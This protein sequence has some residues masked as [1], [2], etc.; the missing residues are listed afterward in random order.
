MTS[1]YSIN[2]ENKMETI[3]KMVR[4]C[5]G[6]WNPV[7]ANSASPSVDCPTVTDLND[8]NISTPQSPQG[9]KSVGDAS[10]SPKLMM[11]AT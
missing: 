9:K 6:C 5:H 8:G 4:R 2:I 1:P 10:T 7:N 11:M 3:V